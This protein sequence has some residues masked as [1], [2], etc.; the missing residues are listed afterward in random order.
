MPR[1][2]GPDR[3]LRAPRAVDRCRRPLLLPTSI[4]RRARPHREQEGRHPRLLVPDQRPVPLRGR[5]ASPERETGHRNDADGDGRAN[6]DE[7][8]LRDA[9]WWLWRAADTAA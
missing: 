8:R 2:R 6:H 1:P 3:V 4:R 9:Q 7:G 5:G